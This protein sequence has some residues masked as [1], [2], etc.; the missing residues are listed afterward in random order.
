M[1]Q[2][3]ALNR[4]AIAMVLPFAVLPLF[5]NNAKANECAAYTNK[6]NAKT[7]NEPDRFLRIKRGKKLF[8]TIF[9]LRL[10]KI[11]ICI[12][13]LAIFIKPAFANNCSNPFADYD[14]L[15][16]YGTHFRP[17]SAISSDSYI[18]PGGS[19][20]YA[21]KNLELDF[22]ESI[23]LSTEGSNNNEFK[24]FNENTSVSNSYIITNDLKKVF[25][26]GQG[27]PIELS[28]S[29]CFYVPSN[30]SNKKDFAL[31]FDDKMFSGQRVRIT[32][33]FY[34]F[35]PIGNNAVHHDQLINFDFRISGDKECKVT[36]TIIPDGCE[37]V[38]TKLSSYYGNIKFP[39]SAKDKNGNLRTDI[40]YTLIVDVP[41]V[42]NIDNFERKTNRVCSLSS[43]TTSDRDNCKVAF[44]YI[45]VD[46]CPRYICVEATD[47]CPELE[48]PDKTFTATAYNFQ[49]GTE[50]TWIIEGVNKNNTS[51]HTYSNLEIG[52]TTVANDGTAVLQTTY[53]DIHNIV[54][55]YFKT[56]NG[57]MIF[58][59]S[60]IDN[61][62]ITSSGHISTRC[63]ECID[64]DLKPEVYTKT[65]CSMTFT[66]VK[67]QLPLPKVKEN[68]NNIYVPTN[69]T[70]YYVEGDTY[71]T[72]ERQLADNANFIAGKTYTLHTDIY[73]EGAHKTEENLLTSCEQVFTIKTKPVCPTEEV[74]LHINLEEANNT[75]IL[76]ALLETKSMD[77]LYYK[78]DFDCVDEPDIALNNIYH[79]THDST[80]DGCMEKPYTIYYQLLEKNSSAPICVC[81]AQV[82]VNHPVGTCPVTPLQ[83]EV[84]D[85][86]SVSGKKLLDYVRKENYYT[87]ACHSSPFEIPGL[88]VSSYA[89]FNLI[90]TH[91]G[92]DCSISNPQPFKY[93]LTNTNGDIIAT[94]DATIIVTDGDCQPDV[95][96]EL[97]NH[98]AHVSDG[99]TTVTPGTT[100]ELPLIVAKHYFPQQNN[101]YYSVEFVFSGRYLS[102]PVSA[103][104]KTINESIHNDGRGLN[105][106]Y[107]IGITYVVWKLEFEGKKF[108][109]YQ[110]INITRGCNERTLADFNVGIST[111]D[112]CYGQVSA[113][114]FTSAADPKP[115]AYLLINGQRQEFD[116]PFELPATTNDYTL[117]YAV[118]DAYGCTY[119]GSFDMKV[120]KP[121]IDCSTSFN[122]LSRRA[123][124]G[125]LAIPFPVVGG[126]QD[127]AGHY[128]WAY[129]VTDK[130]G[131]VLKDRNGANL[132]GK[133]D[134]N[135]EML[136]AQFPD[137][138]FK[139][140]FELRTNDSAEPQTCTK[141][142]FNLESLE[143]CAGNA[144]EPAA[145]TNLV[146]DDLGG[147][148]L[149]YGTQDR[150]GDYH[151]D[152]AD[153]RKNYY[154]NLWGKQR[155]YCQETNISVSIQRRAAAFKHIPVQYWGRIPDT[156]LTTTNKLSQ[157]DMLW[158]DKWN[159]Y[160]GTVE[161][162]GTTY[163]P[164]YNY[165]STPETVENVYSISYQNSVTTYTKFKCVDS[166]IPLPVLSGAT[167]VIFGPQC[168]STDVN[169]AHFHLNTD[170]NAYDPLFGTQ[171]PHTVSKPE[172]ALLKVVPE[173]YTTSMR[174]GSSSVPFHNSSYLSKAGGAE[175][176]GLNNF[177]LGEGTCAAINN[178]VASNSAGRLTYNHKLCITDT[179]YSSKT[180]T[181]DLPLA[182]AANAVAD[183]A[184]TTFVVDAAHPFLLVN[185]ASVLGV[186]V[187]DFPL[188]KGNYVSN[189]NAEDNNTISHV[190]K[191]ANFSILVEVQNGDEWITL[192][193][194][195]LN[196][197]PTTQLG[198]GS[199][200]LSNLNR[201]YESGLFHQATFNLDNACSTHPAGLGFK[202]TET[203][204][205]PLTNYISGTNDQHNEAFVTTGWQLL[206]FDLKDY[207]GR[208]VR[209]SVQN[210]D[211]NDVNGH[212]CYHS[213]YTYFNARHFDLDLQYCPKTE[214][215]D[216]KLS[217]GFNNYAF[218]LISG[219]DTTPL[220]SVKESSFAFR[221]IYGHKGGNPRIQLYVNGSI[222]IDTMVVST[223]PNVK[224]DVTPSA[225]KGKERIVKFTDATTFA[226]SH[227][228]ASKR[229]WKVYDPSP[230]LTQDAS[231][232][233]TDTYTE[234]D[235]TEMTQSI[236]GEGQWVYLIVENNHC[237]SDTDSVFVDVE[238]YKPDIKCNDIGRAV[239]EISFT[240][241]D[242]ALDGVFKLNKEACLDDPEFSF[243]ATDEE[244]NPVANTSID[245]THGAI[246]GSFKE[247]YSNVSVTVA[248]CG[249][250]ATCKAKIFLTKAYN[251]CY[252]ED[253]LDLYSFDVVGTSFKDWKLS[254]GSQDH[255]FKSYYNDH[256]AR[257]NHA[258]VCKGLTGS[259]NPQPLKVTNWNKLN[260]GNSFVAWAKP[261]NDFYGTV[262]GNTISAQGWSPEID[263]NLEEKPIEYV[264]NVDPTTNGGTDADFDRE[265]KVV[266]KDPLY[267]PIVSN[268][269]TEGEI[270]NYRFYI[271][272]T[273]PGYDPLFG[274]T[275]K[276]T[277]LDDDYQ[278]LPIMPNVGFAVIRV[279]ASTVPYHN[280]NTHKNFLQRHGFSEW[281]YANYH[282][283]ADY[284][285]CGANFPKFQQ[286]YTEDFGNLTISN[287]YPTSGSYMNLTLDKKLLGL[288]PNG[289][290][291]A[292]RAQHTFLIDEDN[293]DFRLR[294]AT[295]LSCDITHVGCHYYERKTDGKSLGQYI[296]R[297]P[298]TSVIVEVKHNGKWIRMPGS[299]AHMRSNVC[300]PYPN[301]N[302]DARNIYF[303]R[304]GF[305]YEGKGEMEQE[306]KFTVIQTQHASN[307]NK[308]HQAN[309]DVDNSDG[310]KR[311]KGLGYQELTS[312]VVTSAVEDQY[313]AAFSQ[314]NHNECYVTTGWQPLSFN[315]SAYVGDSAR[316]TIEA[317][318][319]TDRDGQ[320][321]EH[322]AYIYVTS[323]PSK[324]SI[325][326]CESSGM[327]NGAAEKG[328][329]NYYVRFYNATDTTP[330]IMLQSNYFALKNPLLTPDT[331][332]EIYGDDY[333]MQTDSLVSFS[334]SQFEAKQQCFYNYDFRKIGEDVAGNTYKFQIYD[335]D[336]NL[337]ADKMPS[338]DNTKFTTIED[339]VALDQQIHE[340][341]QWVYFIAKNGDC[342]SDTTKKF[343]VPDLTLNYTC[344]EKDFDLG[345][346]SIDS[347]ATSI[348]QVLE[349]AKLKGFEEPTS[350]MNCPAAVSIIYS[351]DN[352]TWAKTES[353]S[354]LAKPL[355][356]KGPQYYLKWR[357]TGSDNTEYTC[358]KAV[359]FKVEYICPTPND[360]GTF[361]DF[362]SANLDD[363]EQ[364]GK[365]KLVAD[366]T[367]KYND[368]LTKKQVHWATDASNV[369]NDVTAGMEAPVSSGQHTLRY[370]V[371]GI[372]N[373]VKNCEYKFKIEPG[374][375]PY[376]SA[377]GDYTNTS[378]LVK[379]SFDGSRCDDSYKYKDVINQLRI[380]AKSAGHSMPEDDCSSV[381]WTAWDKDNNEKE[382]GDN[383]LL[384][385]NQYVGWKYTIDDK[386]HF[387]KYRFDAVYTCPYKSGET[388]ETITLAG[389]DCPPTM[390]DMIKMAE[391]KWTISFPDTTTNCIDWYYYRNSSTKEKYKTDSLVN[392]ADNQFVGWEYK[393]PDGQ[394]STCQY[395]F[396]VKNLCY[397]QKNNEIVTI[398]I[399][400]SACPPTM[401]DIVNMAQEKWNFTFPDSTADCIDWHHYRNATET[402][403]YQ[404]KADSIVPIGDNQFIGWTIKSG[405]DY[406]TCK[407]KFHVKN[408]DC[409]VKKSDTSA[410]D[411]SISGSSC[412]PTQGELVEF[413]ENKLGLT[414]A[415]SSQS[416]ISWFYKKGTAE[417]VFNADALTSKDEQY[418]GWRVKAGSIVKE[419]KYKVKVNIT[420]P[421]NKSNAKDLG[422]LYLTNSCEITEKELV[423]LINAD[424]DRLGFEVPDKECM[425][426]Y[427]KPSGGSKMAYDPDGI[428]KLGNSQ[429]FEWRINH[430]DGI[431]NECEYTFNLK[432]HICPALD[433]LR[434]DGPA[435][436]EDV[437]MALASV[438]P[439]TYN[440]CGSSRTLV[441][442]NTSINDT[443]EKGE[444]GTILWN[445]NDK[446][447]SCTQVLKINAKPFVIKC[448]EVG[449][450]RMTDD[451]YNI[452]LPSVDL[453]ETHCSTPLT[454]DISVFDG[455]DADANEITD[456]FDFTVVGDHIE[457]KA[458]FGYTYWT[459]TAKKCGTHSN[460]CQQKVLMVKAVEPCK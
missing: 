365:A 142:Y 92:A 99:Q 261:W 362:C 46:I 155:I 249:A 219:K 160:Y 127:C 62:E 230:S 307:F 121:T 180:P 64:N 284:G 313:L 420:C 417:S 323:I 277:M 457:T 50:L 24:K 55:D 315:L 109:C 366:L 360:W 398:K 75:D 252:S 90:N 84:T 433:T 70:T 63:T 204:E 94:C 183:R 131:K 207:V 271:Y 189:V 349:I 36:A 274:T 330:M 363:I 86:S 176:Y 451:T 455:P 247:G 13:I 446:G 385:Q 71:N 78:A 119:N 329:N 65:G 367:E 80:H 245:A 31:T 104:G 42:P 212:S 306:D 334:S 9:E 389:T 421:R 397:N 260:G 138:F 406:Y 255:Y 169:A 213:A 168:S 139:V 53:G 95:C 72:I 444:I 272:K 300:L 93:N 246:I 288:A 325:I 403:R 422:D 335:Y 418:V 153:A 358:P 305:A 426:F 278:L 172:Y 458:P 326:Y 424:K 452:P 409:A 425:T 128:D 185:Y 135:S 233:A 441:L 388:I 308:F 285:A 356:K 33:H 57:V 12:C 438:N 209:F 382:V 276:H 19:I 338:D 154:L 269:K 228:S 350:S 110:T 146:G 250:T 301:N 214:R 410:G 408:A 6:A 331:K 445:V 454:W 56:Y 353:E 283:V 87:N 302:D 226:T 66:D 217:K 419:C 374:R 159:N 256:E 346:I 120:L 198:T 351:S 162:S 303:R 106:P 416:C 435:S 115:E 7:D 179:K 439:K 145:F 280:N 238:S 399:D 100:S 328:Y 201:N 296:G 215:I 52:R 37:P 357:F 347:C 8:S 295:V 113:V 375:C 118:R 381:T 372:N 460:T 411:L 85:R 289:Q 27:L 222:L 178:A 354:D 5:C 2:N 187:S 202:Q 317:A 124:D 275:Y 41:F 20:S 377:A 21:W 428:V 379:M 316:L 266:N 383:V 423:D 59:K 297:G 327:I 359:K 161:G 211:C 407:Y 150:F 51:Q 205:S 197:S 218:R 147:W 319:C 190:G 134:K 220:I 68:N 123:D 25:P 69:T 174:V 102:N 136:V 282:S 281:G 314:E 309:F 126:I 11:A 234:Y 88:S 342:C 206:C 431:T 380:V 236:G 231:P 413:V 210:A 116:I 16:G 259:Q 404:F 251:P 91:S 386:E 390:G 312:K 107:P 225:Y 45:K 199:N 22:P 208:R 81:S 158:A 339:T 200:S 223:A 157:Y 402:Q 47:I 345:N 129:T 432:D 74:K 186:D 368:C 299:I 203:N 192:P 77:N 333:L 270:E 114:T 17:G 39:D 394:V 268:F 311:P 175:F 434:I 122:Q 171:Y 364:W 10:L 415:D 148:N 412:S 442:S 182:P 348:K 456:K 344:N 340:K 240:N 73:K 143:P 14:R 376:A 29:R 286:Q 58:A 293:K 98:I 67:D 393:S 322:G 257:K 4:M 196:C 32:Y 166:D 304:E 156:K 112:L 369:F 440:I 49:P 279:G 453:G 253:V 30:N 239:S 321:K 448:R 18:Y 235:D 224:I 400:G 1:R 38:A 133:V 341:G 437:V 184:Q 232:K 34:L 193:K 243:T 132:S 447:Y 370:I 117:N 355:F 449:G 163:S 177:D 267:H 336:E 324:A 221:N 140:K 429:I 194:S 76:H 392:I 264:Y 96:G 337:T 54:K 60:R 151:F 82:V 40:G 188:H 181:I 28:D 294:Y 292:D 23:K 378:N 195:I 244:G 443:Y 263:F 79:I 430:T 35:N 170:V 83:M 396:N 241:G 291:S 137:G 262:D 352:K 144:D 152:A 373:N 332:I 26:N 436:K 167:P 216:V 248:M 258:E 101:P 391:K 130:N 361:N 105:D 43:N 149:S 273:N 310:C 103:D 287:Y 320:S 343:I 265:L 164:S 298:N 242:I 141:E 450:M 427:Y 165:N 395:K 3:W 44:D 108:Y 254:Y 191:E 97:E 401:G 414:F 111:T 405:S 89:N 318:D 15:E 229:I 237:C 459:F 61:V 48:N 125:T 384:Q 227:H 371:S 387:C 173:G 290:G